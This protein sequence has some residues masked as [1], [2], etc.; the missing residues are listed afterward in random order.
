[1]HMS[2][3][4]KSGVVGFVL[5]ATSGCVLIGK[6]S[7]LPFPRPKPII[8]R[9]A[10]PLTPS[11]RPTYNLMG[12][13]PASREGYIDGCETAKKSKWGF[14]D[15]ERYENDGQYRTGWDDGHSIC[16]KQQKQ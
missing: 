15:F 14:K 10:G 3:G 7:Y 12:Y 8:E 16:S 1:M 6:E 13:P 9:P 4:I 2:N 5:F 11:T